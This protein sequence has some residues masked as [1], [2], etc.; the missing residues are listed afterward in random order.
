MKSVFINFSGG[1]RYQQAQ[2]FGSET[3]RQAGFNEV[4]MY[5]E[6]DLD[7]DFKEKNKYILSKSRGVG[8]WSW[9]PYIIKKTLDK[10]EYGDLLFY[11]DSGSYFK[12]SIQPLVDLL[13]KEPSFIL[14]FELKGLIEKHYT[15]RD[16]FVLMG[17]DT[18]EYTESSQRE[19]TYIMLIKTPTTMSIV[20]EYL[21]YAQDYRIITDDSNTQYLPNY[22]GFIDHRHDQSIWSLLMK[23][24]KIPGH[25]L[26]SQHGNHLRQDFP[27]DNYSEI[28]V[29]HR[30]SK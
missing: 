16:A 29:H 23:K 4:I 22:E 1:G 6:N 12:K 18:P 7:E 2:K 28:T 17:L 21:K 9:K 26:I 3:A 30:N 11:S 20:E 13:F 5:N 19:A 14:S 8:C 10:M 27:N 24:H 25:L 15:K